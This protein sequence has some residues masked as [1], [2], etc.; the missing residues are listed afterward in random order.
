MSKAHLQS[1]L[2]ALLVC[3][4]GVAPSQAETVPSE[5]PGNVIAQ[6]E[7]P[8]QGFDRRAAGQQQPN[9]QQ[10]RP[11]TRQE[12]EAQRADE[13]RLRPTRRGRYIGEVGLSLDTVAPLPELY[14]FQVVRR[15]FPDA[16]SLAVELAVKNGSGSQW[17]TAYVVFRSSQH[18]VAYQ[19]EINDWQIDEVVGFEYVFPKNEL[20]AR[21]DKLRIVAV[22]GDRRQSALAEML[23]QSRR[24]VIEVRAGSSTDGVRSRQGDQLRAPGLLSLIGTWQQPVT[25]ITVLASQQA[26]ATESVLTVTMPRTGLLSE[27]FPLEIRETSEERLAASNLARQFHESA[28]GVQ[29]GLKRFCAAVSSAPFSS[30]MTGAAQ[31]P[32]AEVRA[33]L[34]EFN[35]LGVRLAM[36]AQRSTDAEIRGALTLVGA[37]SDAITEQLDYVEKQ[38]KALDPSFR[39]QQVAR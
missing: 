16:D 22:M 15:T 24:R 26:N 30:A 6:T 21:F 9:A 27:D 2:A 8:R 10:R 28:L 3:A 12:A 35:S 4:L 5:V 29:T 34:N 14:P 13:G 1:V 39:F 36:T 33:H 31:E 7:Q 20:E 18:P 32:L 11:P 38:I 37:H 23:S 25:G 17:K 19:F